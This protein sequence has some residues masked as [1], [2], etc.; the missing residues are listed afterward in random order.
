M[1]S[2]FLEK[3]STKISEDVAIGAQVVQL[4]ASDIDTGISGE[5]TYELIVTNTSQ[6]FAV[7]SKSGWITVVSALD[8]ESVSNVVAII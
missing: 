5:L 2:S 8:R 1:F 6:P 7:D 4:T 3:Y